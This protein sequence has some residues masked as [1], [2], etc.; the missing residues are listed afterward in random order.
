MHHG[1]NSPA[2]FFLC[3]IHPFGLPSCPRPCEG[4]HIL[5]PL[6]P[7]GILASRASNRSTPSSI[8]RSGPASYTAE[9]RRLDDAITRA[10]PAVLVQRPPPLRLIHGA[11]SP[12][13]PCRRWAVER[14]RERCSPF[15][16][17]LADTAVRPQ[18]QRPL[19][20]KGCRRIIPTLLGRV[21]WLDCCRVSRGGEVASLATYSS[22]GK[23]LRA[24]RDAATSRVCRSPAAGALGGS[25]Q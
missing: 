12:R 6:S 23:T 22:R 13:S 3:P 17:V 9:A 4:S 8:L 20:S 14:E 2:F 24:R 21:V 15:G 16:E 1:L 5:I 11:H 25:R 10:L 18:L 7:L 19:R